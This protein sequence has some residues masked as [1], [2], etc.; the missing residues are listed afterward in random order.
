MLSNHESD[1]VSIIVPTYNSE[2]F[3]YDSIASVLSQTYSDFELI[4]VDDDSSDD[5]ISIIRSFDDPRIR[6][7]RNES[8]CGP[9]ETR[10]T[11]LKL[12]IGRYIAFLDSDDLWAEDKLEK[13]I[14]FM[15]AKNVAFI[16]TRYVLIDEHGV[17]F[18]DSGPLSPSVTYRSLLPHCI[19]RTSSVVYDSYSTAGKIYF[20]PLRK[21][22]DFGLFLRLLSVCH[23]A[24]LLD[25]ELCSYRIRKNSVSSNKLKNIPYNWDL[26]RNVEKL[27]LA[28]S[29]YY[30]SRWFLNSAFVN[31]KRQYVRRS[32]LLGLRK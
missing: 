16:Y 22:Q 31:I 2:S 12:A 20:P 10:N 26:Y 7:E 8:N 21:R 13:Q 1:L 23:E 17:R 29:V 27:S 11:G 32:N 5:T 6:L 30:I 9:A 15:K 18:G 24:H 19:I 28:S 3:I 25:E 4:I 14:A